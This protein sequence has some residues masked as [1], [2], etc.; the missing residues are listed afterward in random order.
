VLAR[1]TAA[2]AIG[3]SGMPV[4]AQGDPAANYPGK[5]IR[6]VVGFGPGGGNDIF[7]RLVG[8]KLSERLGQP[9]L[10]ENKPG[11]GAA[12]S[13][14]NSSPRQLPMAIRCCWVPRAR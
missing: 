13:Q 9:V 14:P 10:V 5:P 2:G 11:A 8:Q 4:L 3:A 6:I 7:A 1:L 12:S